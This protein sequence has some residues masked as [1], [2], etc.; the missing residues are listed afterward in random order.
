MTQSYSTR[1]K[2]M[3]DAELFYTAKPMN[4]SE[5]FDTGEAMNDA[6]LFDSYVSTV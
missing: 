1:R 6:E 3:N 2:A 4:D 5:L